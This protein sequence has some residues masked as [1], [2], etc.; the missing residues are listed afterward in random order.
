MG[1]KHAHGHGNGHGHGDGHAEHRASRHGEDGHNHAP[2]GRGHDHGHA[3]GLGGAGAL[4]L[5]LALTL[6][7]ALVEF[8]GGWWFGS[9]ALMSDA[10]HM[11][12]DAASLGLAWFAAWVARRP[13]GMRHSF[14]LA[15]AEVIAAFVN[16]L[17][18]LVV[19]LVIAVEAVS[20]LLDPRPVQ[21]AGVMVVAF[22]GLAI[23][24]MVA[25]ILARGEKSLNQRAALLHVLGD[26][27]GSVAA[28]LAGAVIVATGWQPID[29]ILSLVIGALILLSTFHLVRE[30]LHVL[31]EGVPRSLDLE[32]VGVALARVTHVR[33][34]HDLHI[35]HIS[36]GQVALSAH[37]QLD[38]LTHWPA[39]LADA[40]RVLAE[41]FCIEHVT[42]QPEL[43]Q[44]S[45]QG[46]AV[47][48]V[49]KRR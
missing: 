21:G 9:L 4:A 48:R 20:R 43:I 7:F 25:W 47:I 38:D 6:A 3:R 36:S 37:V 13:A 29:P 23:N 41:R 49:F 33:E 2:H 22:L 18:M 5:A 12:S 15:R 35:W 26:L 1:L 24:I 45:G 30:A 39:V 19:V 10:G 16:G 31:M 42:L 14:G 40:R 34:V 8:T 17:A 11:V 32:E 46:Q 44:P 28:L 27:A